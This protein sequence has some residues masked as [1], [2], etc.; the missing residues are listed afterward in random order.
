MLELFH[1][2]TD[3]DSVAARTRIVERDLVERIRFRNVVYPEVQS[4]FAARGGTR[5]PA[6]WD[7]ASLHQGKDAVLAL[8]DSL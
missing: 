6:L 5:L 7:G 1:A 4:D 3:L 8:L 2:L